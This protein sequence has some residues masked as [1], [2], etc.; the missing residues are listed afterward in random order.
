MNFVTVNAGRAERPQA[1]VAFDDF[2]EQ[3]QLLPDFLDLAGPAP[4]VDFGAAVSTPS[5]DGGILVFPTAVLVIDGSRQDRL[6]L[7]EIASWTVT[8][9][10]DTF[11]IEVHRCDAAVFPARL[12]IAFRAPTV[13]A[14][15]AALG[16]PV[17]PV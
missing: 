9:A 6:P 14:L 10:I 5:A 11:T 16:E 2:I 3:A 1:P 17:N 7:E 13:S 15:R 12:P 4:D 8:E